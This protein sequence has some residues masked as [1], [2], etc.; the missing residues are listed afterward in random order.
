MSE[1]SVPL[2]RSTRV[3]SRPKLYAE[4][5]WNEEMKKHASP[6]TRKTPEKRPTK[7]TDEASPTKRQKVSTG[8]QPAETPAPQEKSKSQPPYLPLLIRQQSLHALSLAVLCK[9]SP[10][11]RARRLLHVG[12]TPESL[13]CRQEQFAAVVSCAAE[14]LRT[15]AGG[16][17]Y[18]CGVPGTGKT[19]TVRESVR[20]L[21]SQQERGEL[22]A[23]SFVEINGMKLASPMQAYTEL[24]CAMSGNGQRLSPRAALSK[25]SSFFSLGLNKKR[26]PTVVLMDELDLFVTSRQDVIYNMF[27]WPDLPESN[28]VVIAVANTMDLPE[29]T[30][31]PK[32]ASR[33]G[34]T[35]IPFMPYTDRQLLDIVCARLGIDEHGT[36][37]STAVATAGCESV[38]KVDA[39]VFAS[40][41][42]ANVSGDARRMLDV[43][44]RAVEGAE[45]RALAQHSEPV[46]ITIH[47]IR[48]VMDRMARSGRA[49]HI[50]ALSRHAKLLLASMFA[51]IRRTGV[52]EVVWKDVLMHHA[53]LCRTH[54]VARLGMAESDYNEYE[55]L[56]PLSTLCQLGLVVAVGAGAGSARGGSYAR[57]LLA[58]QEDEV[59]AALG[60]G[61][62]EWQSLFMPR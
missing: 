35:R 21:Q 12:S 10:H 29:R 53:A 33:L 20:A 19:A 62:S 39:L 42:V 56:R 32:V 27:H 30:L 22:P 43:C 61:E 6:R 4:E 7:E 48:D 37:C 5:V 26:M 25:L 40:K 28:L 59:H 50:G 44:R 38:F 23:F 54:S 49:A 3:H 14:A 45:E 34:M 9:M 60:Q 2:R 24:W 52:A 55:L 36:R 51:C 1:G 11:E 58:V 47:D 8:T 15:G 17:A 18:V 31:Q 46:P 16:C 57:Y 41:R 13:P